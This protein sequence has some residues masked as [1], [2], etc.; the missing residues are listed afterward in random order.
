MSP[1][2]IALGDEIPDGPLVPK[3]VP[4]TSESIFGALAATKASGRKPSTP[5]VKTLRSPA[6]SV[7][8]NVTTNHATR[9]ISSACRPTISQAGA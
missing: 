3:N 1:E 4:S 8:A 5:M 7:A 6:R 9:K 2:G